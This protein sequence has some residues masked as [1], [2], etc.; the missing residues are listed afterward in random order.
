MSALS[1]NARFEN[2]NERIEDAARN[3]RSGLR[4][5][6]MGVV[7]ACL[8]AVVGVLVQNTATNVLGVFALV[9]GTASTILGFYVTAHN[10][11]RYNSLLKE[12]SKTE[13]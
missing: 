10:A 2:L 6:S 7:L 13:R 1:D 5:V 3:E 8:G 4:M 12:A 11:H 9:L